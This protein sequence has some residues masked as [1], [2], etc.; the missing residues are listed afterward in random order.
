MFPLLL[1]HDTRRPEDRGKEGSV[2]RCTSAEHCIQIGSVFTHMASLVGDSKEAM[3][4]TCWPS[5]GD[6]Y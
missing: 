5:S 3:T 4:G 2:S 1:S 6:K